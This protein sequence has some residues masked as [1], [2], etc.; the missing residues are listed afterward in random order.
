M[1]HVLREPLVHFLLGGTALFLLYGRV[2]GPGEEPPERIVVTE[3]RIATLAEGFARTWLRPPTRA[4]LEGLVEDFV[5]EEILY[6]EALALGLDRD[7]LV[8]R[9]RMRQKMEFLNQDLV[10][11]VEPSEAE[12]AAFLAANPEVFREPER[13]DLRQVFLDP[14]RSGAGDVEERAASLLERLRRE[15]ELDRAG[16]GLGD[17]TLLPARL[18]AATPE[19]LAASFGAAFA[20]ALAGVPSDGWSGPIASAYGLHLVRVDARRPARLPRLDEVR[21][22]V[23]REWAAEQGRAA[24]ARFQRALRAGYEVEVRLPAETQPLSAPSPP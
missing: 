4:E 18:E 23:E 21:G 24:D 20:E 17:P 14:Q 5:R 11:P 19:E 12:M 8:V 2:A 3:Q 1:R 15:P 9:R 16:D 13:L 10:E 22:A 7:D 6:R